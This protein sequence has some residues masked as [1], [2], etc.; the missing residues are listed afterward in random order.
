MPMKEGERD[1]VV[2]KQRKENKLSTT[3]EDTLYK[4]TNKYG[5]K[6]TV[7]SPEGVSYKRNVTE[8]KKYLKASDMDQ[9]NK[10]QETVPQVELLM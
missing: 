8:V 4:I 6:V 9:S 1:K 7:T 3:F 5:N 2:M 10:T